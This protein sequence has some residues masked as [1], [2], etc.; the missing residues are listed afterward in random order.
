MEEVVSGT[1]TLV[2]QVAEE[3]LCLLACRTKSSAIS[4]YC[5]RTGRVIAVEQRIRYGPVASLRFTPWGSAAA[6]LSFD[7]LGRPA[8]I[9][10]RT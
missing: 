10:W 4:R 2:K 6:E 8:A 3:A 1:L 9:A 7:L 5:G